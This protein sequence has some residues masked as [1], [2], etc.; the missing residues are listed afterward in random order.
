[1]KKT[2]QGCLL[3][4][5]LLATSGIAMA[6]GNATAAQS[7]VPMCQGCHGANG[8]GKDAANGM[9]AFPRLAGQVGSY[10]VQTLNDYKADKRTSPLMG[11]IA[12]GLS[13]DDIANVAAFYASQ[14]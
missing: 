3:I 6:D 13:D 14:K 9:P 2:T 5:F 11:G 1:V 12:K 8:E 7:I 10:L 4:L